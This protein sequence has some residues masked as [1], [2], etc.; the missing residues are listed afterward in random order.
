MAHYVVDQLNSRPKYV[1][2]P[3]VSMYEFSYVFQT[4]DFWASIYLYVCT[5]AHFQLHISYPAA[6]SLSWSSAIVAVIMVRE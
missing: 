4:R 3:T 5:T 1:P 2:I 6:Y